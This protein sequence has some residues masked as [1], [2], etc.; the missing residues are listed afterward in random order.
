MSDIAVTMEQVSKRFRKGQ[1]YDSLRDLIPDLTWGG[2]FREPQLSPSERD[3]WAL[4]DISFEVKK[5][6]A[7]GIIGPNGAGKSTMLKILSRIMRPTRG[8]VKVNGR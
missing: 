5:G 3:F 7:F 1:M 8:S 2:F 6:E 4:Q